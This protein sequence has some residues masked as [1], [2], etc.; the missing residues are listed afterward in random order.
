MAFFPARSEVGS[1]SAQYIIH[2]I[3][4]QLANAP[5]LATIGK[6]LG[7]SQGALTQILKRQTGKGKKLISELLLEQRNEAR[8]KNYLFI[9]IRQSRK[10]QRR[11]AIQI[12]LFFKNIK[13][14]NGIHQMNIGKKKNR[15]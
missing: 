5:T 12:C 15:K 2:I 4:N 10:L 8:R 1:D 13:K 11:Q 9:P 6:E 3:E 7:M 14:N